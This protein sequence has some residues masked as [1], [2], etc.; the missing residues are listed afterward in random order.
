MGTSNRFIGDVTRN[1]FD[2]FQHAKTHNLPGRMLQID[3]SKAFDSISFEFIEK[4]LKLSNLNPTYIS[5]IN[6]L[7][8]NFQSSILINGYPT[9]RIRVSRGC[10]QGNPIAGYFFIICVALLLLKLQNCK[11]IL[12]CSTISNHHKLLDAYAD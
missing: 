9:P 6:S 12:P 11:D 10:R 1:T 5:W 8:K 3:F 4:T 2:L 7:L